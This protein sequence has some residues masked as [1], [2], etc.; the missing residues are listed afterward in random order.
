MDKGEKIFYTSIITLIVV[1]LIILSCMGCT[2]TITNTH[3]VLKPGES[4]DVYSHPLRDA[5]RV[6]FRSW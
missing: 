4:V 6:E 5:S 2:G 1:L 3:R